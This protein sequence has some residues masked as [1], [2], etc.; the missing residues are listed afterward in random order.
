MHQPLQPPVNEGSSNAD[1]TGGTITSQ[2]LSTFFSNQPGVTFNFDQLVDLP[3][4]DRVSTFLEFSKSDTPGKLK[5]IYDPFTTL[6]Y[7]QDYVTTCP[8]PLLALIGNRFH[9]FDLEVTMLA[10]KHERGRGQYVISIMPGSFIPNDLDSFPTVAANKYHRITWDL[11][12][13]DTITFTV[14]APKNFAWRSRNPHGDIGIFPTGYT[15]YT[16]YS[17]IDGKTN[18]QGPFGSLMPW[19]RGVFAVY[20]L[21]PYNAA[22]VGSP[23][24]DVLVFYRLVN[25]RTAEYV[26]PYATIPGDKPFYQ[27][28]T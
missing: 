12:V 25:L 3:F 7:F 8:M 26:P 15:D 4:P 18:Y 21:M 13:S 19:G 9:D 10:M 1:V 22:N 24:C 6:T 27:T 17:Y 5:R 23:D 16:K 20:T 28:I 14:K 2:P 11:E